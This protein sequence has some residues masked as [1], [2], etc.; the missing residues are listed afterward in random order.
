MELNKEES[1]QLMMQRGYTSTAENGDGNILWFI[2]TTKNNICLHVEVNI[3][4]QT[5]KL[6]C[7]GVLKLGFNLVSGNLSLTN[8]EFEQ[9]E[10]Q[11][12]RYAYLLCKDKPEEEAP[13]KRNLINQKEEFWNQIK[14]YV[15]SN[16]ELPKKYP[17]EMCLA[18]YNYWSETSDNG[19]RMRKQKQ[20]TFSIGGR[21]ATWKKIDD[22]KFSRKKSFSDQKAEQQEKQVKKE[23]EVVDKNKLF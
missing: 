16:P 12:Y 22:E 15:S 9:F 14:K 21:L 5:M 23:K 6:D 20:D 1:I 11:I 19:R 18:F 3:H 4:L 7:P 13:V 2:K 10:D 8:K 17:K